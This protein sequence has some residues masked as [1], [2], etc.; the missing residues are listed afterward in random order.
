[1]AHFKKNRNYYFLMSLIISLFSAWEGGRAVFLSKYAQQ[2]G[3]AS[4]IYLNE[5]VNGNSNTEPNQLLCPSL[6]SQQ[7]LL[8]SWKAEELMFS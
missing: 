6:V 3:G 5:A 1:M 7:H 4:E 2:K 8:Y